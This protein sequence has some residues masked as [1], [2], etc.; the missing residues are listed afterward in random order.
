M[1][2]AIER[3]RRLLVLQPHNQTAHFQLA[4][5]L[6]KQHHWSEA[7]EEWQYLSEQQPHRIAIAT[8]LIA[9]YLHR[10]DWTKASALL[11]LWLQQA[12]THPPLWLLWAT[13]WRHQGNFFMARQALEQVLALQPTHTEALY[14]QAELALTFGHLNE[15]LPYLQ[16]VQ[17]LLQNHPNPYLPALISHYLAGC[18]RQLGEVQAAQQAWQQALQRLP[19]DGFRI[20]Q[21]LLLPSVYASV[22]DINAWRQRL[23]QQV[24]LL[25][26]QSL[27]V[28]NPL[29]EIGVTPFLLAYQGLEDV[30]LNSQISQLFRSVLPPFEA[31]LV[32][33][34]PGQRI[35]VGIFSN[36]FYEHASMAYFAGLIQS[37]ERQ[38]F[39]VFLISEAG[40]PRDKRTRQLQASTEHWLELPSHL[41][42]ACQQVAALQLQV[43]LYTEVFSD[44]FSY[45]LAHY[46]L[47]PVQAVLS[48]NPV[49]TGISTLDYFISSGQWES[50]GAAASYSEQLV[51]LPE[52]PV[53]Y[54]K[55]TL[56]A[57]QTRESVG[58]DP[59]YH[60]Y[61]CPMNLL[62]VHPDFDA[63]LTGILAGDPVA[64]I[65][66]FCYKNTRL[67]QSLQGR[68]NRTIPAA[69]TRIEFWPWQEPR[70]L[71]AIL[72]QADV[73]LD[74]F[75][76][77]GGHMAYL[78]L[79]AGTP[80]ITWPGTFLRGRGTQALY[81]QLGLAQWIATDLAD[82][83]AKALVVGTQHEVQAQMR[84]QIAQNQNRIW[85]QTTGVQAF[86]AWLWDILV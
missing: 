22:A 80:I 74:T 20:A 81:H 68:F 19:L 33:R 26:T 34:V 43:L 85:N 77:G 79:A 2:D 8:H 13:Y 59:A 67:H 45:V 37:L 42:A 58:L 57:H 84:Q 7:V 83:V 5:A 32:P 21:A 70:R 14:Q 39:E 61:V 48:G 55:P 63:A 49:T 25:Q 12:P 29:T 65:L 62:K 82:Y 31:R 71:L 72:Q 27:R 66:F 54:P 36:Y 41:P 9:A 23:S 11:T 53:C 86:Q 60:W 4:L 52:L 64:K 28:A 6:E 69:D 3:Y 56:L 17:T 24:A 15:A 38:T 78:S 75:P 46:R 1:A 16:Q 50:E 40:R 35:R 30:G 10:R 73:I 18:Y 76:F 47:A 44:I 51:T